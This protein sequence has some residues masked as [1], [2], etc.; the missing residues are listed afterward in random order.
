MIVMQ[1]G[2][3]D[4][5]KPGPLWFQVSTFKAVGYRAHLKNSSITKSAQR[6]GSFYKDNKEVFLQL[7]VSGCWRKENQFGLNISGQTEIRRLDIVWMDPA[8]QYRDIRTLWTPS[9]LLTEC[10][11]SCLMCVLS[12]QTPSGLLLT[13]SPLLSSI[14]FWSGLSP[15]GPLSPVQLQSHTPLF[16]VTLIYLPVNW[17]SGHHRPMADIYLVGPGCVALTFSFSWVM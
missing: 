9:S 7:S 8:E 1:Q 5:S 4:V 3:L 12:L 2:C 16:Q 6:K 14:H 10:I 11:L 15:V 17:T 13:P